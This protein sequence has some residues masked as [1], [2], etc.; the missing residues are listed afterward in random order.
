MSATVTTNTRTTPV[1]VLAEYE[2]HS[3]GE[4]EHVPMNFPRTL[5]PS[6]QPLNWPSDHRRIPAYRPIDRNLD[7]SQ[8]PPGANNLERVIITVM[9]HGVWLNAVRFI[10]HYTLQNSEKWLTSLRPHPE[11]GVLREGD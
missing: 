7:R 10:S 6:N 11:H 9:L 8:R 3:S 1:S 4:E 2:V 5:A